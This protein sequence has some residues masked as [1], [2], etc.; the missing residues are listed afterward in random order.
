MLSVWDLL[1]QRSVPQIIF[2]CNIK[3]VTERLYVTKTFSIGV[4]I[5]EYQINMY[6]I[7]F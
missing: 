3:F 6:C 7:I 2:Y 4:P 5:S 1:H